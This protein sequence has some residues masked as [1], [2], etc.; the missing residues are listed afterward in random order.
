MKKITHISQMK[1]N[2]IPI[3][4]LAKDHQQKIQTILR[5]NSGNTYHGYSSEV[6]LEAF[7]EKRLIIQQITRDNLTA[8]RE[9]EEIKKNKLDQWNQRV[10][11][12][13]EQICNKYKLI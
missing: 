6:W 3:F 11:A 10:A 5:K 12:G 8:R 2:G 4:D 13:L 7:N 9:I 1:W